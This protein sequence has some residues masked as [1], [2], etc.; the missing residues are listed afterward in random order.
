[1]TCVGEILGYVP[2]V[3]K[4]KACVR[5]CTMCWQEYCT[6]VPTTWSME[7][8]VCNGVYEHPHLSRELV[9]DDLGNEIGWPIH[10]LVSD[11]VTFKDLPRGKSRRDVVW[12]VLRYGGDINRRSSTM[13]TPLFEVN[14][15]ELFFYMTRRGALVNAVDENGQTVLHKHVL[16]GGTA[17]IEEI[18]PI[19][20]V[21][22]LARV[23][24]NF[25]RI[26]YDYML[27]FQ[28]LAHP[29]VSSLLSIHL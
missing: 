13:Q 21:S 17:F 29:T 11:M 20:G 2:N 7:M 23:K 26:P 28:R 15:S 14:D 6:I 4:A 24:D 16:E 25:G 19:P 3:Y 22:S 8:V 9:Y 5:G 12:H 1:M 18:W 10:I 27:C